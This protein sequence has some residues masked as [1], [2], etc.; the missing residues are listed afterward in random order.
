MKQTVE[1]PYMQ[2]WKEDDIIHLVFADKLNIT[3]DVAKHC[4]GERLRFSAGKSYV[5]LIDMKG[6]SGITREAR[7]YLA[8]EG[9]ELIRAGAFIIRS[10]LTEMMGNLFLSINKPQVPTRLFTGEEEAL[11]WLKSHT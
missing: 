10:P 5:C 6:L 7:E 4:V 11:V 1:T 9:T 8:K 3:L 2:M